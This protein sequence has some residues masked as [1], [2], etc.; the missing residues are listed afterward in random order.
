MVNEIQ[1]A[2]IY[3]ALGYLMSTLIGI[4]IIG[5]LQRG[6]FIP[7]LRV[8][9]SLG[10]FV[11]VKIRAVNRWYYDVGKLDQS[12]LVFGKKKER[13]RIN[14]VKD[15]HFYRSLG[16]TWV[17]IDEE[18]NAILTP[19]LKGVTGFD[20]EKQESLLVRA[21]FKPSLE[22][23]RNKIIMVLILAAILAAGLS[24]YFSYNILNEMGA[25]RAGVDSLKAGL[26][27]ATG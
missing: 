19:D 9:S 21:L 7:Y 11:L 4:A 14:N 10:K 24:A 23:H 5:F 18:T 6:F 13:K 1:L 8:R 20:A 22:D 25:L 26:V 17:N 3:Q 16:I 12:D 2:I 15:I 27:V